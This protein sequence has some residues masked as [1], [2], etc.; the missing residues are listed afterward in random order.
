MLQL[1]LPIHSNTKGLLGHRGH[2]SDI[3]SNFVLFCFYFLNTDQILSQTLPSHLPWNI[4][5]KL[6]TIMSRNLLQ[7]PFLHLLGPVNTFKY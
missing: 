5:P 4:F 7:N 2:S 3:C 6:V 1:F